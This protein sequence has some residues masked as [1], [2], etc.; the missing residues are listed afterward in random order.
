MSAEVVALRPGAPR[1]PMVRWLGSKWRLAPWVLEHCPAHDLYCEPYGGSA[2]VLMRKG[3]APVEVLGDLDDEVTNLYQVVRDPA[4]AARLFMLCTFT[5]FA[6]AELRLAMRRLPADAD[7]VERARR[8][9]VRHALQVSPDV[10]GHD[11]GTGFR[12]YSASS[13]RVAAADWSRFPDALE[14]ITARLQGVIIERLPAVETMRKHDRPGALHYVD[15]PYVHSTRQEVR[16]G[17]AHEMT[18]AQHEE[19]LDC[20]LSLEGMAVVSGY[21]SPLYDEALAGWQ[22]VTRIVSDH[23]RQRREEVLWISPAAVAASDSSA[24]ADRQASLF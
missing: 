12:R 24:K 11:A 6:D 16:K 15:P 2:S 3:R 23:A 7:P 21:A 18:D 13:R 9:I 14:A 22:R 4:A 10:R 5:A 17:Y 8:V 20:L 1:R 19:L